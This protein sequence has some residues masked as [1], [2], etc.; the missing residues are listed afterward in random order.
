VG[1]VLLSLGLLAGAVNR[2]VLDGAGS[3]TTSTPSV[4]TLR[5]PGRSVRR[6]PAGCSR[7]IRT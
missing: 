7:P 4:P 5:W 3:P 6:S 2:E 1:S